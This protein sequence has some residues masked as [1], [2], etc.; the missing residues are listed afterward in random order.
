MKTFTVAHLRTDNE[1][2][3]SAASRGTATSFILHPS[4][5]SFRRGFTLVEILVVVVILGIASAIIIPQIGSRD[6]LTAA[7][8]A[9]VMMADLI[10]AQ[11]RAI[12]TQQRQFVWFNGQQ[13]T[14]MALDSSSTLQTIEHPV[15]LTA[16]T[17]VFGQSRTAFEK[18]SL[19]S[20]DFGGPSIIGFDELGSPFSYDSSTGTQTARAS[21]GTIVIKCGASTLTVAVEPFTGETTAN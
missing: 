10:Y 16:Y 9:R 15:N 12:A 17:Q 13:Y 8:A 6:D 5:L 21:A 20:W 4:S 14:L 2:G 1:R 3:A 19:N 7:A 18:V 11:N